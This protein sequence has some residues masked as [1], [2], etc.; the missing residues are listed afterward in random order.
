MKLRRE[1]MTRA[2][3]IALGLIRPAQSDAEPTQPAS[4]HGLP[5]LRLD[6]AGRAAARRH[7]LEGD[8][9]GRELTRADWANP[10]RGRGRRDG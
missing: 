2:R 10:R 1:P 6:H 8:H 5:V 9:G 4:A 3:A 7:L